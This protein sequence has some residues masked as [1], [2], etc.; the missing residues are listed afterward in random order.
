MSID[1]FLST[2]DTLEC[3]V[4][5][6]TYKELSMVPSN[7][8]DPCEVCHCCVRNDNSRIFYATVLAYF[9]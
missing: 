8:S 4:D 2:E 5:G 6:E 9:R 1:W 7:S 3:L